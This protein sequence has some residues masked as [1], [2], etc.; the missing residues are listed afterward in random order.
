MK[1]ISPVYRCKKKDI[2]CNLITET[3]GSC[4][5]KCYVIHVEYFKIKN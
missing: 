3:G 4:D 2:L 1:N 5:W